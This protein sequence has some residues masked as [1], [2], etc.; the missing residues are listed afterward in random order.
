MDERTQKQTNEK[1]RDCGDAIIAENLENMNE[2]KGKQIEIW[3]IQIG[4][5]RNH[6]I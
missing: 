4:S 5:L 2:Y 3:K 1:S 6:Q